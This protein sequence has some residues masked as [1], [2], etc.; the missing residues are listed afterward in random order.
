MNSLDGFSLGNL[1]ERDCTFF[2]FMNIFY[3]H[4][5]QSTSE[6][7]T[8][9][10]H[11]CPYKNTFLDKSLNPTQDSHGQIFL[12]KPPALEYDRDKSPQ[13]R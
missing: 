8:C 5:R 13:C 10:F 1:N 6:T 12:C 3:N 4:I 2:Y 9:T 11:M 7:K